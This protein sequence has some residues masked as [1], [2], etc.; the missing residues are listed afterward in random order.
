MEP[1]K[2]P[3]SVM[4]AVRCRPFNTREKNQGEAS[5]ITIGEE[6]RVAIEVPEEGAPP[7][8]FSFDH[9]Y[10]ETSVQPQV[11]RDLGRPLL[12]KAF[13]GWN[14][15]IFAYGQTGSGKSFSMTGSKD[16]PGIIPHLN[17]EMFNRIAELQA[18]D[19]E[20]KFLVTCS[21]LEIYNEVLY[22]LLD[23]TARGGTSKSRKD[24][25]IEIKEHPVLGVYVQGLQEI[26]A[27]SGEKIQALMD[28]GNDMR[29]VAATNMN[30]TSSRSHS[31]FIIKMQQVQMLAGQRKEVRA[32]I[33]LVDL[34][35]SERV[36]K[37]GATGDKLKEGANINKSLSALGNVINALAEQ[38]KK[39]KKVFIP[40]RNSKLTRVLQESLGGNS[41]TIMLAAISPAAYNFE[42]TLNTLQY[43]DRAKAIQLK[44]RKNEQMTEVGKLKAEIEALKAQM[45]AGGG[46]GTGDGAL[47]SAQQAKM[48]KEIDDYNFM[49]KQSFEEKERL[50]RE[51]E[52]ERQNMLARQ[53]EEREA[54]RRKYEEE[55]KQMLEAN[56][57]QWVQ[58]LLR[59]HRKG[60][61]NRDFVTA[62]E[63]LDAKRRSAT[64]TI[65]EQAAFVSVLQTALAKEAK[66][67]LLKDS[68]RQASNAKDPEK[69]KLSM[70]DVADDMGARVLLEQM[71]LKMKNLR[72]E[73]NKTPGLT[74]ALRTGLD[75]IAITADNQVG[76]IQRLVDEEN[77]V[78]AD[79][80]ASGISPDEEAQV[81]RRVTM[82]Q[83]QLQSND[84]L[85]M[86]EQ[87][88][89]QRAKLDE[90]GDTP[91][92]R[93]LSLKDAT[94]VVSLQA[95]LKEVAT[96]VQRSVE[97]E[98]E[99]VSKRLAE[100]LEGAVEVDEAQK[101]GME[102][103]VQ[104]LKKE[105][106]VLRDILG[107]DELGKVLHGLSQV[108][109][110]VV[111]RTSKRMTMRDKAKDKTLA[112]RE[113]QVTQMRQEAE[114]MREELFRENSALK[115]ERSSLQSQLAELK[116]V[117]VALQ[118][119]LGEYGGLL[120]Q[121]DAEIS[122]L[123]VDRKR[124]DDQTRA[125]LSTALA[126]QDSLRQHLEEKINAPPAEPA[127]VMKLDLG[128]NLETISPPPP[129]EAVKASPYQ[130]G[131]AT[132]SLGINLDGGKEQVQRE[133][134][135]LVG[136]L[137]ILNARLAESESQLQQALQRASESAEARQ[138]IEAEELAPMRKRVN[139]LE[140]QLK[141]VFD[142]NVLQQAAGRRPRSADAAS[143]AHRG[144]AK[145]SAPEEVLVT[146]PEGATAGTQLTVT[147]PSG[148]ELT[149]TVPEGVEAGQQLQLEVPA[150]QV[151]GEEKAPAEEMV[152]TVP[153]G[154]TAGTQLTVTAPNGKE[155]TVTVPEGVEVGQQLQ[156]EVP[157]AEAAAE[158]PPEE[159]ASAAA[160]LL[161][162]WGGLGLS[163]NLNVNTVDEEQELLQQQLT[164]ANAAKEKLEGQLAEAKRDAAEAQHALAEQQLRAESLSMQL[165]SRGGDDGGE[166]GGAGG[167]EGGAAEVAEE[168][169]AAELRAQ[170]DELRG[171][172]DQQVMV[173]K[174]EQLRL[175]EEAL[176]AEET[177]LEAEERAREL[178]EQMA[179]LEAEIE[180]LKAKNEELSAAELKA[181]QLEARLER[182]EAA[183]HERA[184]DLE[185]ELEAATAK[186]E[187]GASELEQAE[188]EKYTL[189]ADLE[190]LQEELEDANAHQKRYYEALMA[191]EEQM[192]ALREKLARMGERLQYVSELK[193]AQS[194]AI[195]EEVDFG[196][197]KDVEDKDKE[198]AR[199]RAEL[200]RV[201]LTV[202]EDAL[203]RSFDQ[204]GEGRY[205]QEDFEEEEDAGGGGGRP[206]RGA[207][208]NGGGDARFEEERQRM[209]QTQQ[210]SD[211]ARGQLEDKLGSAEARAA[212]ATE[213]L[214]K[215]EV[216]T[217]NQEREIIQLIQAKDALQ[218]REKTMEEEIND[219]SN[220]SDSYYETIA[221]LEEQAE[222][223][224][225]ERD[226]AVAEANGLRTELQQLTQRQAQQLQAV[227]HEL[228]DERQ[229]RLKAEQTL[230]KALS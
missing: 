78:V 163:F 50:A 171:G 226:T 159:M 189:A 20:K 48:Q 73:I 6:G 9:A 87:A 7:R 191:K 157:A 182:A 215:L 33:N 58:L 29:A 152:L 109:Q 154:A 217:R 88:R 116:T 46:G 60:D 181:A 216:Q 127:P 121:R 104:V 12:E 151:P 81:A 139:L 128:I 95:S 32:T 170:L 101:I 173:L 84:I 16:M 202:D 13:E 28:Q 214:A 225:Q 19:P 47:T 18:A 230:A 91:L 53:A 208:A 148:K 92:R 149:V 93:G 126:E 117:N 135:E 1:G 44:A 227:E 119:Q 143:R 10:D 24:S 142:S 146:V 2:P 131:L 145:K 207:S 5:I 11:Y 229:A 69:A 132:L 82:E 120:E 14:G 36:S 103:R 144:H 112:A 185:A 134:G 26:A 89:K 161:D 90:K 106:H 62:M 114:Q 80:K 206:G 111:A 118:T 22:D 39:G 223:L 99:Q 38:A 54:Q 179:E 184:R 75:E 76:E 34:A 221:S 3:D 205:S 180:S 150:D 196:V 166:G 4:V 177:A 187:E 219:L 136:K 105:L 130:V 49:L 42:E 115:D 220:Q 133:V 40:Y 156:L 147:A 213:R 67:F 43:A 122:Q 222:G 195:G 211:A 63:A 164:Q 17:S 8:G 98:L 197:Y 61:A 107:R 86:G 25:T 186:A 125:A 71:L 100:V 194:V 72:E 56:T 162:G 193:E 79:E 35:G 192:R 64:E 77:A 51:M 124:S 97:A 190:V 209:R 201:Q 155:V 178:E 108:V 52:Q 96:V 137:Q 175:K 66:V 59:S 176:T 27:D 169:S 83:L 70:S 85:L 140:A 74:D 65:H 228:E 68:Q 172:S 183:G 188:E 21:F 218:S 167:A 198:L 160:E 158:V 30:A 123:K 138:K 141:K 37:T 41:V 110:G 94:L 45:A 200:D 23:P 168:S 153:E 31:I 203:E 15:T 224:K 113:Q 165:K 55:R 102:K 210:H 174:E 212:A 57:D 199:L 129:A 204:L